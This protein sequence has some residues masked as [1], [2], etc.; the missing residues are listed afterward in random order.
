MNKQERVKNLHYCRACLNE[1]HQLNLGKQDVIIYNFPAECKR[2]KK[3]KN[4]VYR[5]RRSKQW[6][7]LLY[8][9][10]DSSG[11]QK[12]NNRQDQQPKKGE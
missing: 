2:C 6:K 7:L 4:I 11:K 1:A 9:R 10:E 8:W 3:M 12:Q 5:V